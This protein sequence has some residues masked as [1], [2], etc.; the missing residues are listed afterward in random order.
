MYMIE[1]SENKLSALSEHIEKCFKHIGKALQCIENFESGSNEPEDDEPMMYSR[2]SKSSGR[3][4]R[5]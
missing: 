5:Y 1:I 2:S 4:R 3:Y